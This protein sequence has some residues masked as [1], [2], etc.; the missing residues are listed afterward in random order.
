MTEIAARERPHSGIIRHTGL[1]PTPN[2][3][4][5]RERDSN[6]VAILDCGGFEEELAH[7]PQ[8]CLFR[9]VPA[10]SARSVDDTELG[11]SYVILTRR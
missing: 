8:S 7:V 3:L 9:N 2:F 4:A 11:R 6:V 1:A 5:W 10:A